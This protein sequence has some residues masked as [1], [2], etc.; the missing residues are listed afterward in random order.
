MASLDELLVTN[1]GDGDG[2]VVDHGDGVGSTGASGEALA[3][4]GGAVGLGRGVGSVV[5]LD[6]LEEVLAALG[7]LD[8]LDADG[9]ALFHV[10]VANALVD[11]EAEGAGGDVVDNGSASVVELVGHALV[12]GAVGLDVDQVTDLVGDHVGRQLGRAVL[13]EIASKHVAGACA[14]TKGVRHLQSTI[15]HCVTTGR[16]NGC[17]QAHGRVRGGFRLHWWHFTAHQAEARPVAMDGTAT[18]I[19]C[20]STGFGMELDANAYL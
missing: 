17:A 7:G 19:C 6:A 8:V 10:A 11:N 14:I 13:A 2:F 3:G 16:G 20:S 1:G 12:D 18:P 5:G 9:D 4:D 15:S